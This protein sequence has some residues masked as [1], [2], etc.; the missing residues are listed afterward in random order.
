MEKN[1]IKLTPSQALR[2]YTGRGTGR[3]ISSVTGVMLG[4]YVASV[5][6]LAGLAGADRGFSFSAELMR[7]KGLGIMVFAIVAGTAGTILSV[8]SFEKDA[9]GGKF[10]RSTAAGFEAFR[11]MRVGM[12]TV[13]VAST[14]AFLASVW[15][16][17][18]IFPIMNNCTS[19]C[20]SIGSFLLLATGLSGLVNIISNSSCRGIVNCV[21][22]MAFS[23]GGAALVVFSGGR[24]SAVHAIAAVSAAAL[25]PIGHR[26][27][28]DNYRE[29][30]WND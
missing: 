30:R 5:L 2:L 10:F 17:D 1:K 21:I 15:L 12:L 6:T 7:E 14:A 11:K 29:K 26:V 23:L 28:L 18:I 22:F 3:W 27:M 16:L 25:I 9:P 4:V 13:I 8:M 20:I 19:V 24:L